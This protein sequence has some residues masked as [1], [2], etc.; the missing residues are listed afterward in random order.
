MRLATPSAAAT[1]APA[2]TDVEIP[3]APMD[4]GMIALLSEM[5]EAAQL[6]LLQSACARQDMRWLHACHAAGL[7]DVGAAL[8]RVDD[9]ALR[10]FNH[11]E[12][13]RFALLAAC[14][15]KCAPT[16][17]FNDPFTGQAY[18]DESLSYSGRKLNLSEEFAAFFRARALDYLGAIFALPEKARLAMESRGAE[19]NQESGANIANA[20]K[21]STRTRL[22][23]ARTSAYIQMRAF[24]FTSTCGA[25]L[26]VAA[27]M[28]DVALIHQIADTLATLKC[29]HLT[30]SFLN[31]QPLQKGLE[32]LKA[33]AG[34]PERRQAVIEEFRR[35]IFADPMINRWLMV[36]R[37]IVDLSIV[38]TDRMIH[39][40]V[41]AVSFNQPGAIQAFI[42]HGLDVTHTPVTVLHIENESLVASG[43]S[44]AGAADDADANATLSS[45]MDA[46]VLAC[47]D[48]ASAQ[49][50][51]HGRKYFRCRQELVRLSVLELMGRGPDEAE[52]IAHRHPCVLEPILAQLSAKKFVAAQSGNSGC[53]HVVSGGLAHEAFIDGEAIRAGDVVFY[54]DGMLATRAGRDRLS[55]L[56]GI[57][58]WLHHVLQERQA[59]PELF[60]L[61]TRYDLAFS[62]RMGDLQAPRKKPAS[63]RSTGPQDG[64]A[65]GAGGLPNESRDVG[66]WWQLADD[67]LLVQL[68]ALGDLGLMLAA[69]R[70]CHLPMVQHLVERWGPQR[71]L[72]LTRLHGQSFRLMRFYI[73]EVTWPMHAGLCELRDILFG[74]ELARML[75]RR[76]LGEF[77]HDGCSNGNGDAS[78]ILHELASLGC[79]PAVQACLEAGVNPATLDGQSKTAVQRA[80]HQPHE[81][82]V[83]VLTAWQARSQALDILSQINA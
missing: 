1:A 58:R 57:Q 24:S 35:T 33:P 38:N 34:S 16:P 46:I 53:D 21:S 60:E 73:D 56:V 83:A 40:F 14:L 41:V 10:A 79:A 18:Q 65:N 43:S 63:N 7:F 66:Q 52:Q 3:Q 36:S 54:D 78:T 26:S 30:T 62:G 44:T 48:P 82:V 47:A 23:G 28:G 72:A 2:P 13:T 12:H 76:G 29:D 81:E 4:L 39:P 77:L 61:I 71:V 37:R 42:D 64:A 15:D 20:A 68:T 51:L 69:V 6:A 67:G 22:S 55:L 49:E 5:P 32:Q 70:G 59:Q 9:R 45:A 80:M 74:Q 8:E 27:A 19:T 75:L 31:A 11:G 25:L 17:S 50:N